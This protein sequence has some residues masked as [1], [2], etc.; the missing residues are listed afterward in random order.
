MITKN[1]ITEFF[2]IADDF[3]KEFESEID[4]KGLPNDTKCKHRLRKWRMRKSEIITIMICFH[5]NS[6]PEFR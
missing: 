4:K 3:C 2:C 5:F 1:K 6:Y